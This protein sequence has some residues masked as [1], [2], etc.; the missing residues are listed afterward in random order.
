MRSA[1][2]T[3]V[4]NAPTMERTRR[5][6]NNAE[7]PMPSTIAPMMTT[8]LR[9]KAVFA[10]VRMSSATAICAVSSASLASVI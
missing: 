8:R 10:S 3:A 6:P 4:F 9:S 1:T 2:P 5:K 7:M